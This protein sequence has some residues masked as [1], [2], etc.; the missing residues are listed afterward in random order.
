MAWIQNKMRATVA[1]LMIALVMVGG[2]QSGGRSGGDRAGLYERVIDGTPEQ[3]VR[4][5]RVV[6]EDQYKFPVEVSA[7]TAIDGKL[8]ARTADKKAISI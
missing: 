4:A 5:A 8:A 2:C 1:G 3:V 7:Y 6:L